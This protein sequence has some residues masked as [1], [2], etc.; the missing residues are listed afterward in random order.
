V[1]EILGKMD[2]QQATKLFKENRIHPGL[3]NRSDAEPIEKEMIE[4][5]YD[6]K[7][8]EEEVDINAI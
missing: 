8:K 7:P 4:F 6:E 5:D 2:A 3:M 1:Y